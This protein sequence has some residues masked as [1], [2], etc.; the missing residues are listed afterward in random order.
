MVKKRWIRAGMLL[1]SVLAVACSSGGGARPSA[2]GDSAQPQRQ[3]GPKRIVAAIWGDPKTLNPAMNQIGAGGS[4]GVSEIALLLNVGM[5]DVNFTTP[6]EPRLAERIPSLDN[7][8]WKLL[9]DGRMETT[10]TIRPNARWH[11][12]TPVSADDLVFTVKVGQDPDAALLRD[13]A[14]ES[15]EAVDPV[16]ART[17]IVRWKAPYIWADSLFSANTVP[18]PSHILESQFT[19]SRQGFLASDYWTSDFVGTGPF[20]LR[21]FERSSHLVMQANDDYI[22]G[23]PKIDEIEVR[24]ILDPSIIIANLMAGTIHMNIGRGPSLEQGLKTRDAWPDGKLD[25]VYQSW[26]ALFPQ[27][28]NPNPAVMGDVRFRKALMHAMDRQA[29]ADTFAAGLVPVPHTYLSPMFPEWKDVEASAVRYDYDPTRAARMIEE[30]GY[31]KG[32]DGFFRDGAGERLGVELR[33]SADDDYKNPLFYSAAD[34]FQRSGVGAE[35]LIIPRQRLE[36]REWRANRPGFEVVRQP[37]DLT[38]SALKRMYGPESA[39]PG[40]GYRGAN[41]TRYASP[42]LDALIN[43]FLITVPYQERMDVLRGVIHHVSDQLPVMGIAYV[44][45]GWLFNNKVHNFSGPVN[46]RNGHLWDLGS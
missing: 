44:V 24:F 13:R 1:V 5:A 21:D 27:F 10:Y 6:V 9:P 35:T 28:I 43:R 16:D 17:A 31:T 11:D 39:L 41:R 46:T 34:Y 23:R 38:E 19:A 25:L 32:S 14:Y 4:G 26:V 30:L 37:N 8:L 40:N 29:M 45:E 15:I 7:G 42:E 2:A 12:G 22:L 3:S 18:L 33:T 36:D 20:K